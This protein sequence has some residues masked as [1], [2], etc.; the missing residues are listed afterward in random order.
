MA[1]SKDGLKERLACYRQITISVIGR[2]SGRTISIP[3]WFVCEGNKL[4][5]LPVQ[6]SDTQWYKN[7]LRH[8]EIGISARGVEANATALGSVTGAVWNSLSR[9][10]E[11][12]TGRWT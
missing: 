2:S 3:V 11:R 8:R 5:L 7:L 10:F 9:S 6:G 1:G 4:Y 12:S